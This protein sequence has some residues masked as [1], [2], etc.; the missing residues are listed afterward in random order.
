MD[1]LG[2]R[3]ERDRRE[4]FDKRVRA[5]QYEVLAKQLRREAD[6]IDRLAELARMQR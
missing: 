6:E 1:Q 4:A 5:N 2:E 3:L